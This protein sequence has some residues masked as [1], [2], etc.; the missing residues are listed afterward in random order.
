MT[1]LYIKTPTQLP[2][3]FELKVAD[4]DDLK[5]EIPPDVKMAL[6]EEFLFSSILKEGPLTSPELTKLYLSTKIAMF[7]REV[8]GVLFLDNAHRVIDN[9]ILFKGTI[10]TVAVY[11]RE[12]VKASLNVNASSVILYHNHPG[13]EAEPS[14]AD[15]GMTRRI[16]DAL[17]LVDIRVLDHFVIGKGAVV[18]FAERGLI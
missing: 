9:E 12:I 1:E 10:D 11:P 15:R 17:S 6:A 4:Y 2:G 7:E 3:C 14:Q 18:S 13:G 5:R 8:F 16:S